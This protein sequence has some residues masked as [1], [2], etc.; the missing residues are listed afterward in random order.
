MTQAALA[1][2]LHTKPGPQPAH[3]VMEAFSLELLQELLLLLGLP[4]V[5]LGAVV[6]HKDIIPLLRGLGL[7]EGGVGLGLGLAQGTG[8]GWDLV[9]QGPGWRLT[10]PVLISIRGKLSPSVPARIWK[11]SSP[12]GLEGRR[13]DRAHSCRTPPGPGAPAPRG[14]KHE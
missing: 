1:P 9:W 3:L 4:G 12:W 7:E 13:K 8:Q 14:Q 5:S 10:S 11:L 2:M 6:S